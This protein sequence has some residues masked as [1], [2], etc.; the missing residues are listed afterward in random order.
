MMTHKEKGKVHNISRTLI[1]VRRKV[2]QPLQNPYSSSDVVSVIWY[3][4]P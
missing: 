2:K 1:T 3:P 4:Y